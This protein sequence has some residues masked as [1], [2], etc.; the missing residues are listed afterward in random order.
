M[1]TP[2]EPWRRWLLALQRRSAILVLPSRIEPTDIAGLCSKLRVLASTIEPSVVVCDAGALT[3]PDGVAVD[4]LA[5]LQ[6]TAR[7]LGTR[8]RLTRTPEKLCDLLDFAGLTSVL[9]TRASALESVRQT[10]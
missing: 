4:A 6:L 10:E 2:Q 1:T 5:R 3:D 7:R 8:I 9:P